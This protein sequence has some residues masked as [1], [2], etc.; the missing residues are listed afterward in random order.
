MHCREIWKRFG[1]HARLIW[2]RDMD[3]KTQST[4][5]RTSSR[6][7]M[8]NSLQSEDRSTSIASS[9][10]LHLGHST[11]SKRVKLYCSV[12]P[13]Q[14]LRKWLRVPWLE[15]EYFAPW[16]TTR[17]FRSRQRNKV[18]QEEQSICYL[19][20]AYLQMKARMIDKVSLNDESNLLYVL[21]RLCF[22]QR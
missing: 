21:E 19:H 18:V 5:Q 4:I 11:T 20:I 15:I 9:T 14:V 17:M 2:V 10:L 7:Q 8:L 3:C 22:R 16:R 6:I 13:S 12:S 1:A